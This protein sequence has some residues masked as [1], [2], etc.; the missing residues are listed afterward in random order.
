[1]K[2]G[3][4][5]F[6]VCSI[7]LIGCATTR[8]GQIQSKEELQL[9]VKSLETQLR[10]KDR[11]IAE[12]ENK[13]LLIEKEKETN[14]EMYSPEMAPSE[15]KRP[16][17]KPT[18][19]EI[20]LALKNAGYYNDTIDGKIGKKTRQAIKD[21]QKANGLVVDGIVGDKTWAKLSKY[22]Y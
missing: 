16:V 8:S 11:K 13:I 1:M 21:F 17:S 6:F 4:V 15:K 18:V 5:I 10:E 9:K 20:Q 12:L 2:S 3:L 22:L 7:C 14:I 19:K